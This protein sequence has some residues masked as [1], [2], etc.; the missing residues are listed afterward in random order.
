MAT[1]SA[2]GS[3]V[4]PLQA[5]RWNSRPDIHIELAGQK[6]GCP[7]SYTTGD[8]IEGVVSIS[9]DSETA[10]DKLD[11]VFEVLTNRQA[12]PKGYQVNERAIGV[13]ET[14][15]SQVIALPS[16]AKAYH[17]FL[18][19]YQ[20]IRDAEY[21]TPRTLVVGRIYRF[22]FN[23]AVP[24]Q[25][26]S[27]ACDH[28][29]RNY[30]IGRA[31]IWLPPSLG[32]PMLASDGRVSLDDMSSELC[33]ISY[34]IRASLTISSTGD[35]SAL[36]ILRAVATKV[37]IIPVVEEEPPLAV[38]HN[39]SDYCLQSVKDIKTGIT[40]TKRGSLMA[41][42]SQ[43]PPLQMCPPG[44]KLPP[45][46][47][48]TATVHLRFDPIGDEPP[49][50]LSSVSSKLGVSTFY[51]I[52]PWTDFPSAS[53]VDFLGRHHY[54]TTV[55]L[56]SLCVSSMEWTRHSG[57]R[58]PGQGVLVNL[59]ATEV[60]PRTSVTEDRGTYYTAAAIVPITLPAAKAFVPTFH[61]CL[62][63]RVYALELSI[64]YHTPHASLLT[65]YISLRL[66]IQ[67][68]VQPRS[69]P[70]IPPPLYSKPHPTDVEMRHGGLVYDKPP[71]I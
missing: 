4:G 55:P 54:T 22:P 1:S 50:K 20:P 42:A 38:N 48:T 36:T 65:P 68:T 43:P 35:K 17:A 56:S 53:Y 57:V 5:L 39:G 2:Q 32:D 59:T 33:R 52:T 16:Q 28:V 26:L 60:P 67:V 18:K 49:P 31:H 41:T 45:D 46:V 7:N 30:H 51:T 25:L 64:S 70:L 47:Y 24:E 66:P 44:S 71:V 3:T 10:F 11:I 58:I 27:T 13:S 40:R 69:R 15:Q 8:I 14:Q 6:E 12:S 21:P 37:R 63:S 34:R 19:L 23:F 61:S 9:V 62:I 29:K